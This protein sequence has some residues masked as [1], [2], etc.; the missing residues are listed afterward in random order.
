ML[1]I[2]RQPRFIIWVGAGRLPLFFWI[3][4]PKSV[5]HDTLPAPGP[6][7]GP[8]GDAPHGEGPEHVLEAVLEPVLQTMG[9]ELVLLEWQASGRHRCLRVFLDRPWTDGDHGNDPGV[10]V[11]DCATMSRVLS[12]ALD[13]AE[14][15][16]EASTLAR[17][18]A[19]PYTLEVSSPG[20]ERPLCRRSHFQ[21]F[22][23]ERA[24]IRTRAPLS[25]RSNQ[26][27]F[28][29]SIESVEADPTRPDDDRAGVVVLRDLDGPAL[30][31]IPLSRVRRANLV[32]QG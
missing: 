31:R 20:V 14:A 9:F 5:A 29:G 24:V 12:N 30:T 3:M 2:L 21:R 25:E 17:I 19:A 10:T 27:T 1:P 15:D 8:A 13:A 22:Q 26:R 28:H 4:T 18:L 16:P 7:P 11:D 32:Y 6:T 23:G